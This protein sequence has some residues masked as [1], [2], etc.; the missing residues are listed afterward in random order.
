MTVRLKPRGRRVVIGAALAA[1]LV[2]MAV[3]AIRLRAEEEEQ[4]QPAM[5]QAESQP[6]AEQPA[7]ATHSTRAARGT[8][9]TTS[10]SRGSTGSAAKLAEKLDRVIEEQ[11]KILARLDDVMKELQIVK[12][13]ATR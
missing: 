10:S 6:P 8:G 2:G 5:E 9:G 7:P 11:E 12:I 3:G 4:P 1:A 13:R